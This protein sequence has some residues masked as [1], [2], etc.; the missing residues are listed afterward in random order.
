MKIVDSD[1]IVGAMVVSGRTDGLP[2]GITKPV[3]PSE[4]WYEANKDKILEELSSLTDEQRREVLKAESKDKDEE[5]KAEAEEA[6]TAQNEVP[7]FFLARMVGTKRYEKLPESEKQELEKRAAASLEEFER[8]VE[9]YRKENP[10][11]GEQ[12]MVASQQGFMSRIDV[13]S[14]PVVDKKG[15]PKGVR[16]VKLKGRDHISS[17]SFLGADDVA[18]DQEAEAAQPGASTGAAPGNAPEGESAEPEAEGPSPMDEEP[19]EPSEPEEKKKAATPRKKG[20][21]ASAMSLPNTPPTNQQASHSDG[22]A[23]ASLLDTPMESPGRRIR[24]KRPASDIALSP[25]VDDR[26][27]A[28]PSLARNAAAAPGRGRGRGVASVRKTLGKR[29]LAPSTLR[30]TQPAFD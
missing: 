29:S 30:L 21:S 17:I 28:R 10:P 20:K 12:V 15:A 14:V 3:K 9:E 24:G 27:V 1:H 23:A 2:P 18:D 7:L 5:A 19:A 6:D 8:Q 25:S 4:L 16:V 22:L 13:D 26:S 11:S